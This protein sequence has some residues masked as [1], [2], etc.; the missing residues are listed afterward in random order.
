MPDVT[1]VKITR[2]VGLLGAG[3]NAGV[4]VTVLFLELALRRLDG[5]EYVAVRQA[6]F[7][8]FTSFVGAV[9]VPTFVAVA[10]LAVQARRGRGPAPRPALVAFVLLSLSLLVTLAVNG[11]INVEQL[12][13]NAAAPPADWADVRDLWQIAHAART[14][15]IVAAFGCLVEAV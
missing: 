4:A 6:E 2:R 14:V 8:V 9:F 15:M 10:A 3:L 1:L 7:G 12:G 11:P 13:W 5:P